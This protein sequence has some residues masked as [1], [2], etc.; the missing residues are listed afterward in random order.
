MASGAYTCITCRVAF[1]DPDLQR[2]HYKTDWHRYNLKRKVAELPPVTAENFR[3][4]VLAQRA[5]PTAE[6]KHEYC[7]ICKKH[8]T[9]ENSYQSHIRSRKHKERETFVQKRAE[10]PE[11]SSSEK[12]GAREDVQL[13]EGIDKEVSMDLNGEQ[14]KEV[15]SDSEFEPEPLEISECL[16]CPQPSDDLESNLKHMSLMH[17]FFIPDLGYLVDIKGLVSHLC[18]KVGVGNM[19]LYCN[20]KGKTF[21]SVE[22]AQHH[23][24]DKCHCKI[25]F[26]GDAALEYAEFYDYSKSYP[27][28]KGD[29]NDKTGEEDVVPDSS[30]KVNEDLELVL[31][32]GAKVGHRAMKQI[33]KQHLPTVEQRRSTVIGRLMSQYRALGW[34]GYGGGD[35]GKK[36]ERDELWTRRMEQAR[37]TKLSTKANK[38]QKHFRP[39][40][41]F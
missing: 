34:K 2:S 21:Y 13:K 40:V 11:P 7:Q 39:Q 41:V 1:V 37:T 36:R 4:R 3:E 27:D 25:F 24:V 23:M 12:N 17:G 9:S 28:Y 18:E 10:E 16:F 19:C 8:F 31:P 14:D 6:A 15:D 38:F 35:V 5:V 30:L 32:S 29:V 20:E 26:E 22:A 33:Y